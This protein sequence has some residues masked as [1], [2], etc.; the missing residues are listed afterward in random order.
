VR[1]ISHF[2]DNS[3]LSS[4]VKLELFAMELIRTAF[5]LAPNASVVVQ[6]TYPSRVA[7]QLAGQIHQMGATQHKIRVVFGSRASVSRSISAVR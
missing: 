7:D 6:S 4:V 1:G 5:S 2:R 3:C